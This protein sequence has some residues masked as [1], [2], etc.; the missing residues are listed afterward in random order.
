MRQKKT[1]DAAVALGMVVPGGEA[2]MTVDT[3]YIGGIQHPSMASS[4]NIKMR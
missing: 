4:R 2:A 1:R 3:R